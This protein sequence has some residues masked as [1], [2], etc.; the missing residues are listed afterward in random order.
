MLTFLCL[1]LN[2]NT[3]VESYTWLPVEKIPLAEN[4]LLSSE[5]AVLVTAFMAVLKHFNSDVLNCCGVLVVL[6]RKLSMKAGV[7]IK[8]NILFFL[9]GFLILP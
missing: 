8:V 9:N 4:S 2:Q 6:R 3:S 5:V 7:R 1:R